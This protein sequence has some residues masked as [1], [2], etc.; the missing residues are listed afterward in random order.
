MCLKQTCFGHNK[1]WGAQ[2]VTPRNASR[3]YRPQLE[4]GHA[5]SGGQKFSPVTTGIFVGLPPKQ[6]FNPRKLKYE[7][8]EISDVFINSYSIRSCNITYKQ[9]DRTVP[10]TVTKNNIAR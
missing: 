2:K 3:G 5:V 7:T 10:A 4:R 6:D 8:L 9:T 1:N